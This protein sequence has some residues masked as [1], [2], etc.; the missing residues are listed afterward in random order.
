MSKPVWD[1]EGNDHRYCEPGYC[2]VVR[3]SSISC[4]MHGPTGHDCNY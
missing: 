4:P 3:N 1:S 2:T